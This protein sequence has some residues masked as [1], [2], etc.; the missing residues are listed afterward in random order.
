[1]KYSKNPEISIFII[2]YN[3]E[4]YLETALLSI[5]NQDF[6][7][8]EIIMVDDCSKNNNEN[9]IKK[10]KWFKNKIIQNE[11]NKGALYIKTKEALYDNWKYVM[12]L[13]EDDI[14]HK[15]MS[16]QNYIQKLKKII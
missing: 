16:F 15:E 2:V 1:M 4:A 6:K 5:Q 8:I 13:D 11:E 10:G 9:L 3:G 12:T 7:D 14:M